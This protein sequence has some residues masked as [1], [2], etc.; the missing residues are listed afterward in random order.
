MSETITT[1]DEMKNLVLSARTAAILENMATINPSAK[2]EKGSVL[3]TADA[4]QGMVL[5]AAIDEEI[6]YQFPIM[7]LRQF[8]AII[9]LDAFKE[10]TM[11]MTSKY[12][13]IVGKKTKTRFHASAENLVDLP[14]GD[15]VFT[16]L[17]IKCVLDHQSY[18][19]FKKACGTLGHKYA[20]I[21]NKGGKVYMVGTTPD[22]DTSNDYSVELG[23]TA[24]AD[25]HI[26]VKVE[27]LKL[28]AGDYKLAAS[29]TLSV[30]HLA[31]MDDRINYYIGAEMA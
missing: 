17:N 9:K 25:A 8:L 5:V 12:V 27:N 14:E 11:L 30:L 16:D 22:V 7:D 10:S 4:G 31:T 24:E 13:D 1:G 3:R 20:R 15:M 19:D 23:E 18:T 29:S 6:P 28:M 26:I 2:I 21:E